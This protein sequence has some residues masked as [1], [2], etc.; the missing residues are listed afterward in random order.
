MDQAFL[1]LALD[2]VGLG[3]DGGAWGGELLRLAGGQCQRLGQL[4]PLHLPGGDRAAREPWRMALAALH[5]AGLGYRASGWLKQHYPERDA[6]PLLTLLERKLRCPPTSSLGRW[7]D[8]AAG[9]LGVREIA[10]YEGQ[11]A[12]ELESLATVHGPVAALKNGFRLHDGELDFTPLVPVLLACHNKAEGAALFHATVAAGLATWAIAAL[13]ASS[14][15]P[16]QLAISGGC[17]LNALLCTALRQ[18]L[19]EAGISLLEATQAPPND[20][21]L[22]LGQGWVVRQLFK[23]K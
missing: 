10:D 22:A 12:M 20:G 5:A 17:A 15:A 21:G 9:L 19:G 16:R 2:G 7:F 4:S 18:H 14:D 8:A 1:G 13:P 23:E 3:P 6:A 11:A